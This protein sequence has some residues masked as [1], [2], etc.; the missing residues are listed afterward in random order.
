MNLRLQKWLFGMSSRLT[1]Q[2]P[3]GGARAL[4]AVIQA[5]LS[6]SMVES[7]VRRRN[8]KVLKNAGTLRRVLILTDI[9]LGD[10]V[11]LQSMATA[12][13]DFFPESEVHFVLSK[14][15]APF[16]EGHPDITHFHPLYTGG[17]LPSAEDLEAV[18]RLF[19]ETKFDL[20][21]NASPFFGPG[22]PIPP[23]QPVLD[24]ITHAPRLIRNETLLAEPN[25]FIVQSY[26]FLSDLFTK[27]YGI[28]R[29]GFPPGARIVLDDGA[30]DQAEA[31]LSGVHFQGDGPSVLLNPDTA[32]K[33]T[34][35]PEAFLSDLLR[36]LVDG[37]MEVLVGEG[38]TDKG[39]GI[40]LRDGLSA[41]RRD[42]TALVPASLRATAYA[43]LTDKVDIFISGDTGPLHWAAARKFSRSGKGTYRNRTRV[44]SLFGA[45]AARMSGYDHHRPG[46]LPAWQ[47]A[48]SRTFVS[49][50]ICRNLSCMN[51]IYKTC[52]S[53]RCFEGLD[54]AEVADWVL[55]G[56]PQTQAPPVFQNLALA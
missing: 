28:S 46:F 13:R 38:H 41:A 55:A 4:D 43:A 48:E 47:D 23:R 29:P 19:R 25:H 9:H 44:V 45:T 11:M 15:A 52:R 16:L 51:K 33:F 5:G 20:V 26:L 17:T 36:R 21:L 27:R 22:R 53:P 2:F 6:G 35:P 50:P 10:A 31:F 37:G 7:L 14:A 56:N 54:P 3:R 12:A 34:R 40:R 8:L 1:D 30:L 49:E 18:G 42:R 24:F 32:S 39:A